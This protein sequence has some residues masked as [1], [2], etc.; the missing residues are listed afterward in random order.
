MKN[1]DIREILELSTIVNS[2]RIEFGYDLLDSEFKVYNSYSE[3]SSRGYCLFPCSVKFKIDRELL[4]DINNRLSN[5]HKLEHMQM[6]RNVFSLDSLQY[7]DFRF[8]DLYLSEI[9]FVESFLVFY[10]NR[11]SPL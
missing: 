8:I 7:S 1:I 3:I 4:I 5:L 6:I 2:P 9:Q 10:C 11:I